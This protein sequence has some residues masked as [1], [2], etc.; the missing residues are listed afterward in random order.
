DEEYKNISANLKKIEGDIISA[1]TIYDLNLSGQ[2]SKTMLDKITQGSFEI[3]NTNQFASDISLNKKLRSTGTTA[4]F[5]YGYEASEMTVSIPNITNIHNYKPYLYL[6]LSQP[7]FQDISGGLT[8]YPIRSLAL[9]KKIAEIQESELM[10]EYFS[11]QISVFYDWVMATES[12]DVALG[13][14]NNTLT[15]YNLIKRKYKSD[16][17]N[18]TDFLRSKENLRKAEILLDLQL[19]KWNQIAEII[20]ENTGMIYTLSTDSSKLFIRPDKY[21]INIPLTEEYA[22]RIR[23]IYEV[24]KNALILESEYIKEQS[25]MR[26]DAFATCKIY[27]YASQK[28]SLSGKFNNNDYILGLKGS[29]NLGGSNIA[30]QLLSNQ[31]K[32]KELELEWQKTSRDMNVLRSNTDKLIDQNAKAVNNYLE[33]VKLSNE[34]YTL[35][36]KRYNASKV[37]LDNVIVAQNDLLNNK[38][39]LLNHRIAKYKN[40]IQKLSLNDQLL[41]FVNSVI[42]VKKVETWR[43]KVVK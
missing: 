19:T 42:F 1:E 6:S 43:N 38:S 33:I 27:E 28:D 20:C 12:L 3:N 18:K 4:A 31:E 26:L 32:L 10:E 17:V 14:Y 41:L 16:L 21:E 15:L 35:E 29:Y 37:L 36:K 7:L 13:N 24:R 40:F 25:K 8:K 39:G 30:G 5:G 34:R 22:N 9:L 23:D 11:K 2:L